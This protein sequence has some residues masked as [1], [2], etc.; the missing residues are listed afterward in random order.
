MR[1]GRQFNQPQFL[2]EVL[3]GEARYPRARNLVFRAQPPAQPLS[4]ADKGQ[5]SLLP[6]KG[7][8]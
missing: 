1:A 4:H 8:T 2:V 7:E 5:V 3:A 6:E